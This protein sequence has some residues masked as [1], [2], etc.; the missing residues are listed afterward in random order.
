MPEQA[1]A[2]PAAPPQSAWAIYCAFNRLA[3]QGFGAW[4]DRTQF[5]ELLSVCQV[6]PGP[7]VVNLGLVLGHRWL[8]WRGAAAAASG[9]LLIPTLLVLMLAVAYQAWGQWP[10]L[11]SLLRGMGAVAAG[12]VLAMAF[13]LAPALRQNALGW[14]LC[15]AFALATCLAVAW[16]RW[17]LAAV[18]LGLGSL[19]CGLAY[20]RLRRQA[21]HDAA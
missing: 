17:P 14:P 12:L 21:R 4:L 8:G 9:L 20:L 5:L 3:L 19:A 1:Q 10:A 6:L 2:G 18:V 16:W 15:A 13:K 7:N 11:A